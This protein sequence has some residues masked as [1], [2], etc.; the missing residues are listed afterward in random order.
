MRKLGYQ[1]IEGKLD[2]SDPPMG[3]SGVTSSKITVVIK[4]KNEF[5]TKN[6]LTE[7]KK[8]VKIFKKIKRSYITFMK[9]GI[10]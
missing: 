9:G 2:L 1:P 4:L 7:V 8:F 5:T 6:V 10:K 3:G